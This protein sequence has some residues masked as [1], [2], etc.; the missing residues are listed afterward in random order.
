M[1][2]IFKKL[3]RG[4]LSK[5]YWGRF[6]DREGK[7]IEIDL[8]VES[9]KTAYQIYRELQLQVLYDYA[10]NHE[11]LALLVDLFIDNQRSTGLNEKYVRQQKSHLERV[12][13][14]CNWITVD[15][16]NI[17]GFEEWRSKA[18][19]S[20]NTK[21]H[22]LASLSCFA[23]WAFV[24][25]YIGENM[26][27]RCQKIRVFEPQKT[28]RALRKDEI[29]RLLE[30]ARNPVLYTLAL[31]TGLRKGELE[32]LTWAD[33]D[34]ERKIIRVRA[35]VGKNRKLAYLPLTAEVTELLKKHRKNA[36]G[37][38]KVFGRIGDT[39]KR[40]YVQ[41][42]IEMESMSERCDFHSLRK[43]FITILAIEGTNPRIL[44]ELARHSN[45]QLTSKV[46]V[47]MGLMDKKS[48]V[49]TLIPYLKH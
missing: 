47:D 30:R 12:F 3:I 16:M 29:T 25:K 27:R 41:A 4:A 2:K 6:K 8:G 33:L 24:R 28:R 43:T 7:T 19:M 10:L 11:K 23:Q 17:E 46:Y 18:C 42:D 38:E 31:S 1:I 26:F 5:T 45:Y 40:D 15:E 36:Q 32:K 22:Y 48:A 39:W 13:K 35:S 20:A 34:L 37:E 49:K 21:N 44:Q 14:Y 9:N